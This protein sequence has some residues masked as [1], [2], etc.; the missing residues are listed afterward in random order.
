MLCDIFD[1]FI[2]CTLV[3]V[4][5]SPC[6]TSMVIVTFFHGL[7]QF[8]H[9]RI[10][11]HYVRRSFERDARPLFGISFHPMRQCVYIMVQL[12]FDYRLTAILC[13]VEI[14]DIG[15]RLECAQ[16]YA[17]RIIVTLAAWRTC[18]WL[19]LSIVLP[20]HYIQQSSNG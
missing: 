13:P 17:Q 4:F 1:S 20:R 8:Y 6:S 3:L 16:C 15:G 2:G 5:S 14:G 11:H 7:I 10:S 12:T 18:D 19:L 9:R